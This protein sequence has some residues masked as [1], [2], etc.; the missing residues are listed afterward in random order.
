MKDQTP[1][2]AEVSEVV[3]RTLRMLLEDNGLPTDV[4]PQHE[5]D[6]LGLKSLDL[7]WLVIELDEEL[8]F[9]PFAEVTDI[10]EVATVGDLIDAYSRPREHPFN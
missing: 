3:Q 5:L 8:G 10:I 4:A 6:A 2:G 9:N 1:M 7:A